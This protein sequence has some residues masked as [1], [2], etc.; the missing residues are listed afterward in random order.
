MR[1]HV[2]FQVIRQF[3]Y[4]YA[5]VCPCTGQTF[6]LILPDADSAMMNLFITELVA[7]YKEYRVIMVADQASWHKSASLKKHDNLRFIFLPPASPELNPAEHLWEHVREK[8]FANR[9]FDSL[10]DVEERLERSFH[11]VYHDAEAIRS[12]VSFSWIN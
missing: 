11:E 6:S 5:T 12:L 1:P 4:V 8:Y 7:H 2:D 10:G 9:V 3:T